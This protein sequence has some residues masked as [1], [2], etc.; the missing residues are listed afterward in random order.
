MPP[1]PPSVRPLAVVQVKD[2]AGEDDQKAQQ[3]LPAKRGRP[4]R[5]EDAESFEK[6]QRILMEKRLNQS[7]R[8]WWF[9]GASDNPG[10]ADDSY[11]EDITRF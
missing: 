2:E 9:Y 4:K 3:V 1:V 11:W 7:C 6:R 10:V 5:K 8:F